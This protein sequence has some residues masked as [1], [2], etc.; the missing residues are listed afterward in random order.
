MDRFQLEEIEKT[1]IPL[2]TGC[3][4]RVYEKEDCGW[5]CLHRMNTAS[6]LFVV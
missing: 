2:E 1:E 6:S 5:S 4:Q 3:K